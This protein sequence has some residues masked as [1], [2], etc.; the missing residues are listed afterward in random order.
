MVLR[1]VC[2]AV[3]LL[4]LPLAAAHAQGQDTLDIYYLDVEGGGGT[5]IVSPSGAAL[6]I[7]AGFPGPRDAERILAAARHA[8]VAQIDYFL[9]THYHSDH[10]GAI[11][12]VAGVLP[13]LN[14]DDSTA[15]FIK[16]SAGDDGSF[17]I[18]NGRTGF[19]K[20]YEARSK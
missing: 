9:A 19:K 20:E 16:M 13:I 12:E 11:A 7:D 2:I 3:V 18:T 8:G 10:V 4:V 5:L 1:P 15:H 6:L 17:T 14:L